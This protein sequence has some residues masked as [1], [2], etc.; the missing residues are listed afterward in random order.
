MVRFKSRL[1]QESNIADG[2]VTTTKIADG[3]IT[4]AKMDVD[5]GHNIEIK[6]KAASETVNN[7]AALQNDNDLVT[8]SL[9]ASTVWTFELVGRFI[10]G[11]STTPDAQ[12]DVVLPTGATWFIGANAN[13]S[14]A[15]AV[16]AIESESGDAAKSFGVTTVA[17]LLILNGYIRIGSTA[18]TCQLRWAQAAAA[19][20]DTTFSQDGYMMV[21]RIA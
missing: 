10:T 20:E 7:S 6:R 11:A 5:E 12:F 1:S 21:R 15:D 9:A 16:Q 3:T 2:A 18:G 19:V 17:R 8:S 14:T 4:N 13:L